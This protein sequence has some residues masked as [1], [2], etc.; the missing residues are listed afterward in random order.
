MS[1]GVLFSTGYI[2]GGTIA[3]VIV[4][5]L[6]LSDPVSKSLGRWQYGL[7][8][9][10]AAA[11]LDRQIEDL[12]RSELGDKA[13]AA[14]TKRFAGEIREINSDLFADHVELPPGTTLAAPGRPDRHHVF[15]N[16]AQAVCRRRAGVARQG[17]RVWELNAD[18]LRVTPETR[19]RMP[20]HN[21]PAMVAFSLLALFLAAVG[22]GWFLKE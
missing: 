11:T 21:L 15:R 14:D 7:V 12:A 3:G 19:V 17:G 8:P 5:F 9:I 4:S 1:P 20:Q 13:S 16:V 10:S 18:R 6:L 2:A 22:V